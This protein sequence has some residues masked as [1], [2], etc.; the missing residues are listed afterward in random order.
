MAELERLREEADDI[1]DRVKLRKQAK[2]KARKAVYSGVKLRIG[3]AQVEVETDRRG[4][5][6][7]LNNEGEIACK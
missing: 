2:I 5:T 4:A 1:E 3:L 6:Y 7:Y